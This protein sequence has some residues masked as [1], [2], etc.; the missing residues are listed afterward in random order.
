MFLAPHFR[1][2][3]ENRSLI[4]NRASGTFLWPT[5]CGDD[6]EAEEHRISECPAEMG[7]FLLPFIVLNC[8]NYSFVSRKG[9]GMEIAPWTCPTVCAVFARHSTSRVANKVALQM[10]AP[11]SI[12]QWRNIELLMILLFDKK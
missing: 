7:H 10:G 9:K 2:L 6:S 1:S 11:V 3:S 12:C 5:Y 8:Q 4:L